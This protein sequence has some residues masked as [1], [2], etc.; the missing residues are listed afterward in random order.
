MSEK[1]LW[2]GPLFGIGVVSLVM[3]ACSGDPFE[4]GS[5]DLNRGGGEPTDTGNQAAHA[6]KGN[7]TP[8][9]GAAAA[10]GSAPTAGTEATAE[11][12]V[13]SETRV[14]PTG[15]SHTGGA[16]GAAAAGSSSGGTGGGVSD[17]PDPGAAGDPNVVDPAVDPNCAHPLFEN[18]TAPLS[19]NGPWKKAFGDPAVDTTNHQ[20][21]ISFDDVAERTQ[22][23]EGSYY[24]ESDVTF[25]GGTAFTPYPYA[26]EVI[27]PSLRRDATGTGI[28]L[29][30]TQ[31]GP[32]SWSVSGWGSA[33][34]QV[35][36]GATKLRVGA[37]LQV[38][39]KK[40]A[41]KVSFGDEVYRSSWV[42][43]FDWGANEPGHHALRG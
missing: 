27:L 37:Y 28:E 43:G 21:V 12:G 8:Q 4:I 31:Y 41:V 26:S 18:W 19:S 23:Y 24:L 30:A 39:S 7:N 25:E 33:S 38:A 17:P 29:G 22:P 13:P 10:A 36:A 35:L 2:V 9:G 34:G 3:L 5:N 40:F 32:K 20:L 16:G 15:G 6:G 14:T 11:G 42:T 1:S